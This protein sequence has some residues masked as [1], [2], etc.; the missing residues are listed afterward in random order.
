MIFILFI[1]SIGKA[2]R[3]AMDFVAQF[4]L[5]NILGS[6]AKER[7]MMWNYSRVRR[8]YLNG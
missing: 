3:I 5:R 4:Y 7:K 6:T 1:K 8:L 2:A